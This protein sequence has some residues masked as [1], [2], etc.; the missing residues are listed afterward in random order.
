MVGH[1]DSIKKGTR[2]CLFLMLLSALQLRKLFISSWKV[3]LNFS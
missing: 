3:S 2:R 1:I